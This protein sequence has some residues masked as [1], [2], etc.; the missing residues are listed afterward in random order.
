MVLVDQSSRD[1]P[2]YWDEFDRLAVDEGKTMA[3]I[4]LR[5]DQVVGALLR[6]L[7]SWE[8]HSLDSWELRSL[9]SWELDSL[10]SWELHSLDCWV[11]R[12]LDGWEVLDSLALHCL[13]NWDEARYLD[14]K[15]AQS[16][17]C[18]QAEADSK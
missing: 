17:H 4:L 2:A 1:M 7:D 13:D 8:L 16:Y 10:D 12:C 6:S 14:D 11:L 15:Q 18:G 5:K 3:R 9:D